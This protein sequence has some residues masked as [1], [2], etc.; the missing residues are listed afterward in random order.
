M[1]PLGEYVNLYWACCSV[2]CR[3]VDRWGLISAVWICV[4]SRVLVRAE[5]MR[6]CM[7]WM[8]L[9]K[10]FICVCMELYSDISVVV[11]SNVCERV[12]IWSITSASSSMMC[13][14]SVYMLFSVFSRVFIVSVTDFRVFSVW[15]LDVVRSETDLNRLFSFCWMFSSDLYIFVTSSVVAR[16]KTLP[17]NVPHE[18]LVILCLVCI[19]LMF[20]CW[21]GGAGVV[22]GSCWLFLCTL[23]NCDL[24]R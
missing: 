22:V 1:Y 15:E 11:L 8:E 12:V 23:M 5:F 4:M 10:R 6:D 16:L 13:C 9:N 14:T 21:V 18:R 17:Q 3:L 7:F 2:S 20:G 19:V 24:V